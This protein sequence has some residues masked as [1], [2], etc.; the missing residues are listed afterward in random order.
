MVSASSLTPTETWAWAHVQITRTPGETVQDV[1]RDRPER[2]VARLLCPRRLEP[3]RAYVACVVPAF[4]AGRDTGLGRQ[5]SDDPL[6][7]AWEAGADAE[8]PVY[9][10]WRFSTGRP[11]SFETLVR[12]LRPRPV[13]ADA[14]TRRI[15]VDD[16]GWGVRRL[17]S[18]TPRT[19]LPMYG[20]LRPV[21]VPELPPSDE[22]AL[23]DGIRAAID[24]VGGRPQT[25]PPLYGQDY[26]DRRTVPGPTDEPAWLRELNLDPRARLAAGLGVTVV[27]LLQEDFVAEAWRQLAR[28]HRPPDELAQNELA[29]A[30]GSA[31][32]ASTG[33][34]TVLTAVHGVT[35]AAATLQRLG[36]P[37]GALA[38]RTR[39]I[40]DAAWLS[41]GSKP[42]A[43]A[44]ATGE[45]V[46]RAGFAPRLDQPAYELLRTVHPDWV[47]P[48]LS[49]L[50][51]DSVAVV[52]TSG[53]FAEAFLVGLNHELSRELLWRRYPVD[54]RGTFFPSFW[55]SGDPVEIRDWTSGP[56]G[57]HVAHDRSLV[58]L[59][60]GELLRRNPDAE[61]Y[62]VHQAAG[63][64]PGTGTRIEPSFTGRWGDDVTLI[65]F[66]MTAEEVFADGS[67]VWFVI[68]ESVH[69][70]RFGCDEGTS[71]APAQPSSWQD[72]QWGNADF[73]Q[74]T[75]LPAAGPLAGVTL[76][77]GAGAPEQATWG[78]DA[79]HMAV[80]TQQ[81]PLRA[82]LPVARWRTPAAQPVPV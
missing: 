30:M 36:R 64:P 37:G 15:T 72:L 6:A 52:E 61:I 71:E 33:G 20:L 73:A 56:L 22:P 43:S 69:G 39:A 65:G 45:A 55:P 81:P 50:P 63:A 58:L 49:E 4:A 77:V 34:G 27:R 47:L 14:A 2:A 51:P 8:L 5:A 60:R 28:A 38:R 75:F 67:D 12:A 62:G 40:G 18:G 42:R 79:A 19:T 68:A 29:E 13:A 46:P 54:R 80:I 41:D 31:T 1:L 76:G 44:P 70:A 3:G 74:R 23:S 11:G 21:G 9:F 32:R 17:P 24:Q 35:G 7:P 10:H 53:G 82:V 66:P 59:V 16:P 57:G 48:G 78:T 25:R 26:V